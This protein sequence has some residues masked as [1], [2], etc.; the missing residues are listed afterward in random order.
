M[1]PLP[2][3]RRSLREGG[4]VVGA[5]V[6]IAMGVREDDQ[7]TILTVTHRCVGLTAGQRDGC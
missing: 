3:P 2:G 1:V 6:L 7:R 4:N 5:A